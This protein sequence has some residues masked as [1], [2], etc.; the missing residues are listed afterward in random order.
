MIKI[1]FFGILLIIL[2]AA[3]CT[4]NIEE[5]SIEKEEVINAKTETR[6]VGDSCFDPNSVDLS[7]CFF[8][9]QTIPVTF[10]DYPGC[11][12]IIEIAYHRCN[13]LVSIDKWFYI[14]N[15]R[16]V[17]HNCPAFDS[18]VLSAQQ[19]GTLAQFSLRVDL[20]LFDGA[21]DHLGSN[22]LDVATETYHYITASCQQY[23]W[24]TG[25]NKG[26]TYY[27]Y[28]R[29]TCGEGCCEI[30]K[31]YY[32]QNGVVV[33]ESIDVTSDVTYESCDGNDTC[34]GIGVVFSSEC[35]FTCDAYL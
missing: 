19:N 4:N 17:S 30:L 9:S 10:D 14:E 13:G 3:S 32:Y 21:T 34:S 2:L 20:M 35:I 15:I 28:Y 23:C 27:S 26:Y 5:N 16:L 8:W 11:T 7:P 1:K 29:N 25:T 6:D 18:D 31:I 33:S 24:F 12:F 22:V